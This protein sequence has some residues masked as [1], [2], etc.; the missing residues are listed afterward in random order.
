MFAITRIDDNTY[1]TG[2]GY[3]T[4]QGVRFTTRER[5]NSK[6]MALAEKGDN[7]RLCEC[8]RSWPLYREPK[9]QKEL[10]DKK[11]HQLIDA[12]WR[13]VDRSFALDAYLAGAVD[14]NEPDVEELL[15][16][17]ICLGRAK[18]LLRPQLWGAYAELHAHARSGL[19]PKYLPYELH[20][21]NPAELAEKDLDGGYGPQDMI[22]PD[23]IPQTG[24]HKQPFTDEFGNFDWSSIGRGL[25]LVGK[26]LIA[27]ALPP[28][29]KKLFPNA[30]D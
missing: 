25:K 9:K 8:D 6:L 27:E 5:A 19:T 26:S 24:D 16:Q 23:M 22:P 28:L 21:D 15:I 30:E 7:V 3:A 11:L 12:Q 18:C 4:G 20:D 17:H 1:W 13:H 14:I 29:K 2:S 10:T